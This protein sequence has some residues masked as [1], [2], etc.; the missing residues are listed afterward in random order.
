MRLLCPKCESPLRVISTRQF[1]K[2]VKQLYADCQTM[3]CGARSVF[4][5]SFS[6]FTRPPESN[7][8]AFMKDF[9][10]NLPDDE[11]QG[12]IDSLA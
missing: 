9:I 6:H 5:V 10:N 1:S 11:K 2:E 3:E 7:Y 12:L 8:K 4:H